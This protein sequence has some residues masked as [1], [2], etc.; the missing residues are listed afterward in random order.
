MHL[1]KISKDL[2]RVNDNPLKTRCLPI[3]YHL[4]KKLVVWK[5]SRRE[6]NSRWTGLQA[7]ALPLGYTTEKK[8]QGRESNPR[9]SGSQ[10]DTLPN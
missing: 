9:P 6:S 2:R 10:P 7:A 3:T 5:R 1:L 4:S 8:D